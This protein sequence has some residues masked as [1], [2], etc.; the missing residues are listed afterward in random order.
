MEKDLVL[1]EVPEVLEGAFVRIR[2]P[3]GVLENLP[4]VEEEAVGLCLVWSEV[5]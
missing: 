1:D 4:G 2:S 5:S 3:S